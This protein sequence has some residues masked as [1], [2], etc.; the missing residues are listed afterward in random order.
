MADLEQ[1]P[2]DWYAVEGRS[3]PDPDSCCLR[4][5]FFAVR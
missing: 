4:H 3:L 2:L 5:L 1:R